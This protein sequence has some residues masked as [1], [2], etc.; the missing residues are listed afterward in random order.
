MTTRTVLGTCHHD[1]PD[2]CGWI[3]TVEDGV[4]VKLR[5]NPGHPYSQ[6]E[7]CPKVNH[8]ID[9]VYSPDRLL[10]PLIRKGTK[11]LGEFEKATWEQALEVVTERLHRVINEWGGESVLP[12]GD[13]GTQGLIQMSSLDRRF[14]GRIG[15]SLQSGSLCGGTASDGIAATYGTSHAAD[16]LDLRHAKLVLLWG[17]NTKLTNRH[18]WPYVEEARSNGAEIVA[19]D[20]IRTATAE[21]ADRHIQPL[22]GTDV[23]LMLGMMNVLIRDDLLDHDYIE[24]YAIGFDALRDHVADWTPERAATESGLEA[25]VVEHLARTYAAAQPAHIRTLIGA[26]HHENGAMFFRALACLPVLTGSWRHLGG[27]LSKSTGSWSDANVDDSVFDSRESGAPRREVNMNHLGRALT[28]PEMSPPVQALFVWNGNPAVTVPNSALIRRGLEREDLFTVVGEQF[29]TDT[30]RY[31]DVIFPATTQLEQLDVVPAWGHL[32]LGWNEPAIAPLGEAVPNTELWRRLSAAMGFEGKE[33]YES[34]RSLIESAV[35]GIDL[36]DLQRTG[37]VRVDVPLEL[38]PYAAG[39]FGTSS[40]RAELFSDALEQQGLDP[41][42]TFRAPKES[43]AGD[44]GLFERYPLA[45]MTPKHHTRFLNTSYTHLPKHG[46]REGGP[47]VELDPADAAARG[48]SDGDRVDV[49]NDRARL[50]LPARIS[51][52]LRPGVVAVPFGWQSDDHGQPATANSL[53]SDT[54][55]EWGGGVAYS[56]TLVQVASS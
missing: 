42:P 52:R 28:D 1:C 54:L 56:D 21:A 26:E 41:L 8:F 37:M 51:D 18:L 53:T 47:F 35:T 33:F 43:P 36:G 50:S 2:S 5:G 32:Y 38:L 40:G 16:P 24:R 3:A 29:M 13:A 23:A 14:F 17:T 6:G 25:G 20:P 9:R 27:G 11:G 15:S 44:S 48:I 45:L 10:H 31:A 12:W 22:P 4:A 49:W 34:D 30:A 46:P 7:L 55:T 19:I 39:G